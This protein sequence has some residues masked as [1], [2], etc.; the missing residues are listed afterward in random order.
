MELLQGLNDKQRE[1]V[2]AKDRQ[3]L[4]LA[5]AGS[6]KTKTVTHKIA[7]L[8]YEEG[9]SPHHIM[10]ITFTNKAAAE[11]KERI[12]ALTGEKGAGLWVATFHASCVR[13]L[14][15]FIDRIGYDRDFTIYDTADQRSLVTRIIK[16]LNVDSKQFSARGVLSKIS[17]AK[18]QGL[19]WKEYREETFGDF[20]NQ[21]VATIYQMYEQQL[22]DA[23]A[24]DF[25]DLLLKTVELLKQDE[26]VRNYYSDKFHYIFVD[27]YQDTNHLQFEMIELLAKNH[28]RLCVV[29]DDDQSIYR[30]RGADIQNIL[31]FEQRWPKARL[32]K[33]EQNYRSTK[34]ILN[35]ANQVIIRNRGRKDKRLWTANDEGRPVEVK[36]FTSD[37]DEAHGVVSDIQLKARMG[38][39]RYSDIA[40]LYRSNAQSRVFEEQLIKSDVP[41]KIFG[42]TNF[43]QRKEIK[44]I[45]AYLKLMVNPADEVSLTRIVNVPRRGIG[46]TTL[47]RVS[48]FAKENGITLFEAMADAAEISDLRSAYAAKVSEF[49]G[50]I[51]EFSQL[52]EEMPLDGLFDRMMD[53]SGYSLE[54]SLIDDPEEK[55]ERLSNV[56]EFRNKV[57]DYVR[58]HENPTLNEFLQEVALISD[59]DNLAESEDYVKLM[60]VHSSKGLEFPCVYLVGL[61]ENLFPSHLSIEAGDIEVE[62]E[63]RL[64]YVA[65]TRAEKEL[66]MTY[67]TKRLSN[68]QLLYNKKSR[69]LE[70]TGLATE[71][72][73]TAEPVFRKKTDYM[74]Y[75][76]KAALNRDAFRAPEL[77][78]VDF[79]E[80]DRV[81]HRKFGEGT[82]K[83][84]ETRE[85]QLYVTV[86]FDKS[87][88]K[89]MVAAYAKLVKCE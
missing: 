34:N 36:Q 69:F 79:D 25:D 33:L 3:L 2:L 76:R 8:L 85:G 15:R 81:R 72:E 10:A 63:R 6:G 5:G 89:D 55:A 40:I 39:F 66:T 78:E 20:R 43:Y 1:A 84:I 44:D 23:N 29:G 54:L 26:E 67:A 17:S 19:G 14:R 30:F 13:I 49:A 12:D 21:T 31:G 22:K 61:E 73:F 24:L 74:K 4:I 75:N 83:N 52:A 45:L 87:G 48:A 16:Q 88:E 60:T 71:E 28:E 50:M 7:W 27:E 56:S 58:N 46:D 68:G 86:D 62:E 51:R 11:M 18:N 47:N 64:C 42:G 57:V 37:R 38:T 59:M 82:V 65:I 41:Y 70:E 32:I 9:V 77:K 80:G 35:A 53:E